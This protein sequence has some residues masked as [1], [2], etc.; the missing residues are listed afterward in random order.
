VEYEDT[1]PISTPEGIELE[2]T[3]AGFGSRF[4]AQLVDL[5]LRLVPLGVLIAAL[6]AAGGGAVGAIVVIVAYFAAV[7]VYDVIFEVWGGGRTPGKRWS[8]L[9]VVMA[10]GQ[11]VGLGPSAVRNLLRLI[12]EWLTLGIV[13]FISIQATKRNQRLG[14]LAAGTIVIRERRGSKAKAK[15]E[16]SLA[17]AA[18]LAERFHGVDVTAVTASD[19]AAAR[20][21]LLRRDRLKGDSRARV[22]Q[23]LADRLAAKIG[24]L[25]PGGLAPEQL[26]EVIVTAKDASRY[27]SPES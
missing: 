14:D 20:D 27:G 3:L 25:P 17:P 7:F 11:P 5:I 2:Y 24:G 12:D 8:G 15:T 18:A 16:A 22:A 1:I 19:L 23:A 6:A 9:R 10:G 21:F 4:T 13:G 26:L